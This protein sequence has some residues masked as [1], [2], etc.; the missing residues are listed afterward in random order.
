MM[1]MSNLGMVA[2]KH[3]KLNLD[4][5]VWVT[6]LNAHQFAAIRLKSTTNSVTMAI[7]SQVMDVQLIAQ[8]RQVGIVVEKAL[9]NA[10]V[11]FNLRITI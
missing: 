3:V 6:L 1:E 7:H 2:P 8:L 4:E 10:K 11:K 5:S 9:L